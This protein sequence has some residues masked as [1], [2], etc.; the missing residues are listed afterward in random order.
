MKLRLHNEGACGMVQMFNA[1]KVNFDTDGIDEGVVIATLPQ[2]AI[3]TK[4]VVVVNEAFD[5]AT[6]NVLTVGV[7]DDLDAIVD[8][9]GVTGGTV[10]AYNVPVFFKMENETDVYV[11]Y[12]QTGTV[13]TAG[14]AEI[15]LEVVFEPRS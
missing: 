15:Y 8:A 9:S 4:A 1:G 11:Q 3:I 12:A 13:A 5:A 2:G 10:G 6:T 14:G 7:K